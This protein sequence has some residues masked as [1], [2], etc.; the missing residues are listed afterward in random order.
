MS[1]RGNR[2][3]RYPFSAIVGQ[4]LL[5]K[6]LILNAVDESIGGVLIFGQRGTAKS[7]AAR[8]LVDLLPEQ[9]VVP[10][11]PYGCDPDDYEHMC[12]DCR[13]RC[14]SDNIVRA[15]RKMKVI[16]LPVSS[17]EDKVI[18]T[19]DI[20]DAIKNGKRSFEPGILAEANRNILYVDEINLL[21]DH[22]VDSILDAAASG[23]NSM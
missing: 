7:T 8:A 15:K 12:E 3:N 16:D 13:E 19:L 23:S 6:S 1:E 9:D 2:R 11:C 5:K 14:D 18:G 17:T 22:I 10:G 21:N 4:S 20:T